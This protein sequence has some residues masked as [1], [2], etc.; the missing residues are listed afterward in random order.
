MAKNGVFTVRVVS[1]TKPAEKGLKKF[2]QQVDQ[3]GERMQA[4]GKKMTVFATLP[5]AGAMT[6][7]ANAASELEQAVGGTEAV[8]GETSETIDKFAKDSAQNMGL[9]EREFRE[10]TTSIGGQLKRMTGDVELAAEQSVELTG[11]AADLAA[12]YGGT[13]A[14]A[15]QALGAAFRGEADPAERFN[16]NLKIGAQNAKAVELGL[17]ASTSEVDDNAR[18]QALLALIM[19]Q[20]A[21]AQGQF[22]RESDT[23][24]GQM[25]RARA[26]LEDASAEIGAALL[27]A[28]TKGA[29]GVAKLAQ[30]FGD[31]PEPVQN[32]VVALAA[33]V[34]AIGPVTFAAGKAVAGVSALSGAFTTL[35]L[36]AMY[37]AGAM[38]GAGGLAAG[39]GAVAAVLGTGVILWN[40][41]NNTVAEATSRTEAYTEALKNQGDE[42]ER[43]ADALSTDQLSEYERAF[44][45][46]GVS[47][48]DFTANIRTNGEAIESLDDDIVA[49]RDG[50]FS[51]EEVL[52][53]AGI[54]NTELGD[55]LT[56]LEQK[57]GR[58]GFY[59]FVQTMDGLSDSFDEADSSGGAVGATFRDLIGKVRGALDPTEALTDGMEDQAE[60][61]DD[62]N[63]AWSDY[64]DHIKGM[65]DPLIAARDAVLGLEEAQLEAYL[66]SQAVAEAEAEVARR[67]REHGANSEETAEAVAILREAERELADKKRDV[68]DATVDQETSLYNLRSEVEQ[69]NVEVGHAVRKLDEW[70]AQ[71]AI[72]ED[73]AKQTK[74]ELFF[75]GLMAAGLEERNI[76]I[77]VGMDD[78]EFWTKFD[79]LK[80][81]L[82]GLTDSEIGVLIERDEALAGRR[83]VGGAVR[84]N[85]P[86]L[87]GRPG[88]EE[89]FVP[90]TSGRVLSG[91]QTD[92]MTG[93]GPHVEI[94]LNGGD[95][96]PQSIA[97]HVA[98][99][100]A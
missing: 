60:T 61:V 56:I 95:H 59:D 84:A 71:G 30:N 31:L 6:V 64:S 18:A 28:L 75:L 49:Y 92:R 43:A 7:A 1:D 12:T 93:G 58:A 57:M 40:D 50:A 69:G 88:H 15:V 97:R 8:F 19:E 42:A 36:Q 11:A 87:I 20:S 2:T 41:H 25:Q 37:A 5:I 3:T 44:T 78:S 74:D 32:S 46:A 73:Q 47:L 14:E 98:W 27:P 82:T 66:A 16:L 4:A 100:L 94:N 33:V 68:F 91:P 10:A 85:Q 29:E 39:L 99:A 72:T 34:A 96:D 13:T 90:N 24:A 77:P 80:S 89:M 23:A 21:D 79:N 63:D 9:S 83:H 22:A 76:D 38:G 26:E 62:A 54:A 67:T 53:R 70:V 86:Y 65:Y 52:E 35:R 55:T 48:E 45:A 17:A 81:A 51:L